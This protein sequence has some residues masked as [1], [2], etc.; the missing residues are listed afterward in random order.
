MPNWCKAPVLFKMK[1]AHILCFPV[2]LFLG[3]QTMWFRSGCPFNAQGSCVKDTLTFFPDG[4]TEAG[5][6]CVSSRVA[7]RFCGRTGI[8][9]QIKVFPLRGSDSL[10]SSPWG[11]AISELLQFLGSTSSAPALLQGHFQKGHPF[12]PGPLLM[13]LVKDCRAFGMGANKQKVFGKAPWHLSFG[14]S[15]LCTRCFLQ[16]LWARIDAGFWHVECWRLQAVA[17]ALGE[18]LA[19][20][21]GFIGKKPLWSLRRDVQSCDSENRA[22]FIWSKGEYFQGNTMGSGVFQ[23]QGKAKYFQSNCLA[24]PGLFYKEALRCEWGVILF[25]LKN[26]I[27][28]SMKRTEAQ[29]TARALCF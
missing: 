2:S 27:N 15:P 8:V 16:P 4:E 11:A 21:P 29:R 10:I 9:P 24:F 7:N 23:S 20:K 5:V 25:S 1:V 28:T 6:M 12:F 13:P 17:E 19:F 26:K 18:Q 14:F 22:G 3:F